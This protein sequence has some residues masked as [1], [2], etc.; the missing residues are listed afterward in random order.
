MLKTLSAQIGRREWHLKKSALQ[1][2]IGTFIVFRGTQRY[3]LTAGVGSEIYK[4]E[5]TL[6][7]P[8]TAGRERGHQATFIAGRLCGGHRA[9]AFFAKNR[10]RDIPSTNAGLRKVG[11]A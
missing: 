11:K 9:R 8:V 1:K 10:E 6:A 2:L 3:G 7:L 4:D 5:L